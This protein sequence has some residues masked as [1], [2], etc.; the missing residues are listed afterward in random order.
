LSDKHAKITLGA[1]RTK[2]H[3]KILKLAK[4]QE[5]LGSTLGGI[6]LT[7]GLGQ[8]LYWFEQ[9]SQGNLYICS[10]VYTQ[11]ELENMFE[12]ENDN[13]YVNY[14]SGQDEILSI[15]E[16]GNLQGVYE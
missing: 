9:D 4:P 3:E 6:T 1:F 14:K 11:Q 2:L 16:K 10:D 8:Y 7:N 13:L 15:D 5:K 12:I